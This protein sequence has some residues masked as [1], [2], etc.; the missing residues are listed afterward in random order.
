MTTMQFA[1]FAL[2]Q[3]VEAFE[4]ESGRACTEAA[5]QRQPELGAVCRAI[6]G[7]WAA[8]SGKDSPLTQAVAVGMNGEVCDADIDAITAFYHSRRAPAHLEVCPLAHP[9]L[10]EG[11]GRR[12]YRVSEFSNVLFRVIDAG[13]AFTA[14]ESPARV[15]LARSGERLVWTETVALGFADEIPVTPELIGILSTFGDRPGAHLWLAEVEGKIAGG[16]ALAVGEG[17]A[18]LCGASTLPEHRRGGIQSGL[19]TA[20]LVEAAR[21][22]CS[23]AYTIAVPGSASHRNAE[24]HGFRV[25]YTR[26]KFTLPLP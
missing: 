13:E 24:R 22:G 2:A 21:Q 4:A 8:Y 12:G 18:A 10:I 3:R 11:L 5:A 15:R 17:L 9:T 14:P 7:G 16:G 23:L 25:A 19:M 1:E 6:G 20:R 26:I